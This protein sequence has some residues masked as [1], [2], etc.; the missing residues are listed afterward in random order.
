MPFNPSHKLFDQPKQQ[1]LEYFKKNLG[2]YTQGSNQS[3]APLNMRFK[4]FIPSK[5]PMLKLQCGF[6]E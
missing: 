3:K 6:C 4:P 5:L 1:S 2:T